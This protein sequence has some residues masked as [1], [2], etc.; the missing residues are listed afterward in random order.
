[1]DDAASIVVREGRTAL[2][3]SSTR[4]E[5]RAVQRILSLATLGV[6]GGLVWMFLSGGGF[7]QLADSTQPGAQQPGAWNNGAPVWPAPPSAANSSPAPSP[8]VQP[9]SSSPAAP[10]VGFGPTI[11]I[12]SFNIHDFGP[13]KAGKT[14][15][16]LTLAYI[17]RQFDVVA[18]QEI[19]SQDQQLIP[20]FVAQINQP[21]RAGEAGR[22]YDFIIGPRVGNSIAKEQFAYLFDAARILCDKTNDYTIGDPDNLISREPYVARF[23][24]RAPPDS[25]FTFTLINVHT[26]PDVVPA[27]LDALAEVY[28]VV[29]RAGVDEDD[30]IMLGDFNADDMNLGRLGQIPGI[31]PLIRGVFTN[32]RQNKLYDN[33]IIHQPSTTEVGYNSG[34]YD[35]VRNLNMTTQQAEAVSDHFP[36][37]AEFSVYERDYAGNVA[38]RSGLVR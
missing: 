11:K 33:I 29:R 21:M 6:L 5:R 35:I 34:V 17:V 32:T 28:R 13:T 2:A 4:K 22:Q 23:A 25:A 9:A 1:V 7:D 10:P 18:I 36:V 31:W 19:S 15:V 14:E 30:V 38:Y 24:T 27:E 12:A 20:Q 26:D 16:M 37:W 8:F 3:A